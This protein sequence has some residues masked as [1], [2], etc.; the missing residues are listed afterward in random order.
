MTFRLRPQEDPGNFVIFKGWDG[1]SIAGSGAGDRTGVAV[2]WAPGVRVDLVRE[3]LKN[4]L[5]SEDYAKYGAQLEPH[6]TG[7]AYDLSR[8]G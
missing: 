5:S 6:K 2:P 4:I 8:S 1:H 7:R 3:L